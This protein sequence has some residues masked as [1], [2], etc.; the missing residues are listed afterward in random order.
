M[1]NHPVHP[2]T[3]VPTLSTVSRARIAVLVSGTGSNLQ[4]LIDHFR[5]P[6]GRSGALVW[7]GSN[8]A[9]AGAL[10][11]A[12]AAGIATSVLANLPDE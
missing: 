2:G 4:A 5:G 9:D 10:T 6:A 3:P 7:V 12:R 8:R 11:L 1:S